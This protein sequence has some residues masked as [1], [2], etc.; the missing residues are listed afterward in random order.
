MRVLVVED[1]RTIAEQLRDALSAHGFAVDIA[2]NGKDAWFLGETESYDVAILDLGL[3]EQDGLSVL[4]NWRKTGINLPVLI[5]TARHTWREKV[6][7]LRTGADDY[8]VK[9][10]EMEEL[11]ARVEVLIRRASGHASPIITCGDLELDP[12]SQR[13][14]LAGKHIE[15]SALE[16]RLISYLMHRPNDVVSKTVLTEHLYDQDF[17]HDSNVIEVLINRC[18]KKLGPHWIKTRR[19]QG[20]VLRPD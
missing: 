15:L 3:P 17:N 12:A 8:L 1:D 6:T 2:V 13:I 16:Y 11:L 7:G 9:P 10:F 19:G 5:L 4:S 14:T 18:R 20:Y